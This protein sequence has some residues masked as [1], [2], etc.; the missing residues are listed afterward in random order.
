MVYVSICIGLSRATAVHA[1]VYRFLRST[2]TKALSRF[3]PEP[4]SN[5]KK[6]NV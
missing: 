5:Y 1:L 6:G 4:M 2:L 3:G